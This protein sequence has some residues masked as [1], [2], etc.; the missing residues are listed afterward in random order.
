MGMIKSLAIGDEFHFQP[1]L[2]HLWKSGGGIESSI[3]LLM[4]GFPWQ[5]APPLGALQDS[6]HSCKSSCG[7][8][9]LVMNNM[10]LMS[11]WWLWSNFRNKR[12][13]IMT[14][15]APMALANVEG[16]RSLSQEPRMQTQ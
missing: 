5:L 12:P 2:S 11:P 9:G 4:V 14:K 15:D 8:K 16:F 6:P 3:L 10:I 13:N 1:L 7:G